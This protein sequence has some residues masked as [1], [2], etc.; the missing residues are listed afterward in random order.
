MALPLG[1]RFHGCHDRE[2]C[3]G[4]ADSPRSL[5]HFCRAPQRLN[6]CVSK[7][8]SVAPIKLSLTACVPSLL[9]FCSFVRRTSA[10]LI[11]PLIVHWVWSDD[12]MFSAG[13]GQNSSGAV[14]LFGCGVLDFA[15]SGVVHV[16]GG[17]VLLQL[18]RQPCFSHGE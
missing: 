14:P 17:T 7:S 12:G 18:M 3:C 4:T 6:L 2:R 11:D 16:T 8:I 1:I 13:R 10:L 15:G 5:P 9:T